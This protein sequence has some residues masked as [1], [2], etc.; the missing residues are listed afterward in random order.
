MI[1]AFVG[2][3]SARQ[4]ESREELRPAD[5]TIEDRVFLSYTLLFAMLLTLF[6][7]ALDTA[8]PRTNVTEILSILN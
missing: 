5:D 7:V 8:P 1:R 6:T 3:A 2:R 4:T